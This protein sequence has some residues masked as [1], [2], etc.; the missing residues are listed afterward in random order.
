MAIQNIDDTI[1]VR[2]DENYIYYMGSYDDWKMKEKFDEWHF[3][4]DSENDIYLGKDDFSE[5]IVEIIN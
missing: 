5:L 2:N 3:D 4:Y 1:I